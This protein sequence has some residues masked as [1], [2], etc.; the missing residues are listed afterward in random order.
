MWAIS[1]H[2][3]PMYYGK[4]TVPMPQGT[5]DVLNANIRSLMRIDGDATA[6]EGTASFAFDGEI[7]TVCTQTLAGGN[8]AIEFEVATQITNFGI[9][10]GAT[11]DWDFVIEASDD[12]I[13]WTIV[14]TQTEVSMVDGAWYWWDLEGLVP[15]LFMRIRATGLTTILEIRELVFANMPAAI[16]MA[17]MNRDDYM[18]LPNKTFLGKPVQYMYDKQIRIPNMVVWPAPDETYTFWQLEVKTQ[19]YIMDPGSLVQEIEVP[20]SAYL[21][22]VMLLAC[23]LC[24]EIPE[25]P[26]GRFLE[27]QP[28][29]DSLM[30]DFWAG[31]TDSAPTRITPNIAPYTR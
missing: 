7:D 3:I 11:G 19:R 20:Q 23:D 18:N 4:Q 8:I 21:A 12:G 30:T 25:A 14:D 6:S 16:P 15:A 10:P 17:L 28:E 24:L 26:D 1:T 2:L 22:I 31:Q 13:T 29:R 9:L 5:I 27:L